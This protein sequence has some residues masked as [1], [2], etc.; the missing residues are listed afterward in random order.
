MEKYKD[1]PEGE[2]ATAIRVPGYS[3]GSKT[4]EDSNKDR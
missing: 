1:H 3:S 2:G 4:L